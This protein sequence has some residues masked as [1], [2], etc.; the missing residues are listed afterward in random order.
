MPLNP[1]WLLWQDDQCMIALW[2]G[3]RIWYEMLLQY[4]S[5]SREIRRSG[6]SGSGSGGWAEEVTTMDTWVRSFIVDKINYTFSLLERRRI[7]WGLSKNVNA[8]KIL[9]FSHSRILS[10]II[11]SLLLVCVSWWLVLRADWVPA[12]RG[13]EPEPQSGE[14]WQSQWTRRSQQESHQ[15]QWQPGDGI[16]YCLEIENSRYIINVGYCRENFEFVTN[17]S[18]TDDKCLV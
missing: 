5:R 15:W 2:L 9:T 3:H 14:S 6:V 10:S 1:C 18:L 11:A 13:P 12:L 4:N 7:K 8:Y 16:Q 17:S